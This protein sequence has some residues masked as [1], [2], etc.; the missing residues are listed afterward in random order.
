MTP[1][2]LKS[3][4][5][6]IPFARRMRIAD[7]FSS[8]PFH[9]GDS[10][11]SFHVV[12]AA[13]GAFIGTC[14]SACVGSKGFKSWN[15]I[16]FVMGFDKVS[17]REAIRRITAELES[18]DDAMRFLRAKKIATPMTSDV[19]KTL[20]RAV[21]GEDVARFAVSRPHSVTP[22]AE[23][24]NALGFK[25]TPNDFL[26]CAYRLGDTFYTVKG[27]RI[28]KKDFLQENSVSQ[29][30]L[31]NIDAVTEGCDVYIVESELDVACLYERGHIAVSVVSSTQRKIEPEVLAKLL[32]AGRIILIGDNDTAGIQCM[33]AIAKLLPPEK[34]VRKPLVGAKDVGE[35]YKQESEK[36][37]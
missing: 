1:R 14:F 15:A 19:W 31:F 5:G 23:T 34:T 18:G 35:F 32:T 29:K 2:E 8:C 22:S 3:R 20:G 21:T 24:L 6:I 9:K 7:G 12:P 28:T 27:R 30:G 26:V 17:F 10:V 4:V 11:T 25:M 13:D 37:K 33:D 36:T 16:D